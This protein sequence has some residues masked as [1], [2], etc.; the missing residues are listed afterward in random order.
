MR[1]CWPSCSFCRRSHDEV[2]RLISGPDGVFICES[3][4]DPTRSQNIT[5]IFKGLPPEF[6]QLLDAHGVLRYCDGD[7]HCF[8]TLD[9]AIEHARVHIMAP[10]AQPSSDGN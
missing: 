9:E 1:A 2:D 10:T 8:E 6:Q 7:Q 4:V 3:C 5:V